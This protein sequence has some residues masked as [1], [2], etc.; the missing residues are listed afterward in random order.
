MRAIPKGKTARLAFF[1]SKVGP[2]S[3]DPTAIGTTPEAVAEFQARLAAAKAK[4]AEQVAADEA[5]K[6]ATAAANHAIAELFDIGGDIIEAIRAK[7]ASDGYSIYERAQIAAPAK[8]SPITTLGEP[9]QFTVALE[10][11]GS[12]TLKWKCTSPRSSG[13]TYE[14]Y[15]KVDDQTEFQHLGGAGRKRFADT[16]LP[17]GSSVVMYKVRAIRSSATGPWGTHTVLFGVGSRARIETPA[18][19]GKD[20]A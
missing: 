6:A 5:S 8:P 7:A 9:H 14:V 17:P 18:M 4:I 16:T 12:L 1:G 20:A 2:W 15:R 10:A 13:H 11:D 3:A 19:Q